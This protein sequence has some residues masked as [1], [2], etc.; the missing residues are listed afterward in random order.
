MLALSFRRLR[1]GSARALTRDCL[2]GVYVEIQILE[3]RWPEG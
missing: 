2:C 1:L 3:S